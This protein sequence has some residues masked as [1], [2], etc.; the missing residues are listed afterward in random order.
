MRA[1]VE[2]SR[3]W[4]AGPWSASPD[5]LTTTLFHF[6]PAAAE[7]KASLQ[8]DSCGKQ[9]VHTKAKGLPASQELSDKASFCALG[10]FVDNVLTS[11]LLKTSVL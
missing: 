11:F 5:S 2:A 4:G 8:K 1:K 10:T 9:L 7:A 3:P 6:N